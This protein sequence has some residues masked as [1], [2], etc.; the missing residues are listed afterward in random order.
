MNRIINYLSEVGQV[1]DAFLKIFS[2]LN[3]IIEHAQKV[4][5]MILFGILNDALEFCK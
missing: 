5:R 3:F 4:T 1:A 2:R